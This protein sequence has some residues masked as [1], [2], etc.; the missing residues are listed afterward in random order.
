MKKS[1]YM[2]VLIAAAVVLGSLIG[3]VALGSLGWLGYSRTFS[4]EPGTFIDIDVLRLTFGIT[5]TFNVAQILLVLVAILVYYK[6]APK[7][8]Q[9]K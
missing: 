5:V 9:G 8:I 1:L 6:T 2:I 3:N 4:F 7:L